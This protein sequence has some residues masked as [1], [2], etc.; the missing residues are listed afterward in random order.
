M[1]GLLAFSFVGDRVTPPAGIACLGEVDIL[2]RADD[3]LVLCIISP[4]LALLAEG[5]C[6]CIGGR[7]V[8]GE[9]ERERCLLAGISRSTCIRSSRSSAAEGGPPA[10]E[11][12]LESV[13]IGG[14]VIEFIFCTAAEGGGGRGNVDGIPVEVE[15][16]RCSNILISWYLSSGG[17]LEGCVLNGVGDGREDG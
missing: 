12:E 5:G 15:G 13:A 1:H 16:L 8:E 6:D 3:G 4:K 9:L 10:E 11:G 14:S 7:V 17:D 2:G